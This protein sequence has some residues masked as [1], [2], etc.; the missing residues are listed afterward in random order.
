MSRILVVDD[1]ED[2]RFLVRKVLE[3]DGHDVTEAGSGADGLQ[4]LDEGPLPD[5]IVLDVQMPVMDGWDALGQ[6]RGREA[7][8][9][10]PVILAT[11]KTAP[12]A[13]RRGYEL[14]CDGYLGKP[15]DLRELSLQVSAVL[16]RRRR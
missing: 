15:F 7:T 12:D 1:N 3:N 5:L 2:V 10:L 4:L 8:K 9:D 16:G 13:R 6:I 11:V 14:G